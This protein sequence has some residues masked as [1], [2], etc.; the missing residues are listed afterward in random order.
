VTDTA[1]PSSTVPVTLLHTGAAGRAVRVGELLARGSQTTEVRTATWVGRRPAGVGGAIVVK[2]VNT[3]LEDDELNLAER[4]K[5]IFEH[6]Q[7]N[8]APGAL[9]HVVRCWAVGDATLPERRTY[10]HFVLERLGPNVLGLAQA[11]P[12]AHDR[13][14]IARQALVGALRAVVELARVG[15]VSR[16]MHPENILVRGVEPIAAADVQADDI[17]V[18]D[19]GHA[20]VA[21]IPKTRGGRVGILHVQPRSALVEGGAH[22]GVIDDVYSA[23]VCAYLLLSADGTLPWASPRGA[24]V[25]HHDD[26][27]WFAPDKVGSLVPDYRVLDGLDGFDEF[28]DLTTAVRLLLAQDTEARIGSLATVEELLS[29]PGLSRIV[30]M[31]NDAALATI[32]PEERAADQV[33]AQQPFLDVPR[34]PDPPPPVPSPT[35]TPTGLPSYLPELAEFTPSWRQARRAPLA[36]RAADG[37]GRLTH[38]LARS[39]RR[40]GKKVPKVLLVAVVAVG[41]P[42]LAVLGLQRLYRSA[43]PEVAWDVASWQW[44]QWLALVLLVGVYAAVVAAVRSGR[45]RSREWAAGWVAI[46]VLALVAFGTVFSLPAW[47]STPVGAAH[48]Q[49]D[50]AVLTGG[51]TCEGR[52]ARFSVPTNLACLALPDGW[53]ETTADEHPDG[54]LPVRMGWTTTGADPAQGTVWGSFVEDSGG[55]FAVYLRLSQEEIGTAAPVALIDGSDEDGLRDLTRSEPGGS[56]A[57][58]VLNGNASRRWGEADRPDAT[59]VAAYERVVVQRHGLSAVVRAPSGGMTREVAYVVRSGC[60]PAQ[61]AAIGPAVDQLLGGLEVVDTG[62]VDPSFFARNAAQLAEV[63]SINDIAVPTG[64]GVAPLRGAAIPDT[65]PTELAVTFVSLGTYGPYDPTG[66][67]AAVVVLRGAAVPAEA[68]P[69]STAGWS[70]VPSVPDSWGQGDIEVTGNRSDYFATWTVGAET[71]TTRVEVYRLAADLSSYDAGLS[72]VLGMTIAG[73]TAAPTEDS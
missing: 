66:S 34:R 41:G 63:M 67:W 62:V 24:L 2:R 20:Y 32:P 31:S 46:G 25:F 36:D 50:G 70:Q 28:D 64:R 44:L 7:K 10:R 68:T 33:V 45:R 73:K 42:V 40:G 71:L 14:L 48:E 29:V 4:E 61:A 1:D 19:F 12:S 13:A 59:G 11:A 8:A 69:S 57:I 6:I 16:D 60:S 52:T 26:R 27:F 51:P 65:E 49:P 5:V 38:A 43:V 3:V 17:V 54:S 39:V 53:R 55:C 58:T 21:G 30:A 9:R 15:V 35:K 37:A 56:S 47:A 22:G 23:A 18:C 72:R